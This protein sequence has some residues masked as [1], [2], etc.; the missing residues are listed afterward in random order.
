MKLHETRKEWRVEVANREHAKGARGWPTGGA[1]RLRRGRPAWACSHPR[2]PFCIGS[3]SVCSTPV[4]VF[5]W[6]FQKSQAGWPGLSRPACFFSEICP[7]F[8]GILCSP[9]SFDFAAQQWNMRA[10]GVAGTHMCTNHINTKRKELETLFYSN[11]N[12]GCYWLQN[13]QN[14]EVKEIKAPKLN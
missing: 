12:G 4:R 13:K 8:S 2:W 11:G 5:W 10:G 9:S 7:N 3:G 1:G 6:F 14:K